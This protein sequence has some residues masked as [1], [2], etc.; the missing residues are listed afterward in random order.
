MNTT[1]TFHGKVENSNSSLV[2]CVNNNNIFGYDV[3]TYTVG[4]SELILTTGSIGTCT[5]NPIYYDNTYYTWPSWCIP[6]TTIWPNPMTN[7]ITITYDP[8]KNIDMNFT[9]QKKDDKIILVLTLAGFKKEEVKI[10]YFNPDEKSIEQPYVEYVAE[11]KSH[12][13]KEEKAESYKLTNK[14]FLNQVKKIN[15]ATAK[16]SFSEGLV[17]IEIEYDETSKVKELPLA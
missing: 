11:S 12:P 17:T 1:T 4:G 10:K 2:A 8:Y 13:L 15:F 16:S 6:Q 14:Y 5:I 3:S 9:L 7:N